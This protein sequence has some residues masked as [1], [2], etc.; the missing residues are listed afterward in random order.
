M[1]EAAPEI[2]ETEETMRSLG[3]LSQAV[4][5]CAAVVLVTYFVPALSDQ[6]PWAPGDPAPFSTLFRGNNAMPEFARTIP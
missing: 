5:A 1:S 4:V 6:R 3:L 2:D